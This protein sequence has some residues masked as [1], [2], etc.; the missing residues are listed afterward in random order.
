MA[1]LL[2]AVH[3]CL[4]LFTRHGQAYAVPDFTGT[5]WAEAA[6]L[7][8]DHELR[9]EVT[10]SLYLPNFPRGAVFRQV[11]PAGSL[12]KKQ[13]RVTL[14]INSVQPRLVSMPRL[15]GFSLRQAAAEL[16][17][18]SLTLGKISYVP[19]IATN[20]V[21]RQLRY[22]R[23]VA[24]GAQIE[25]LSAIDLELGLASDE[26][27]AYIPQLAGKNLSAAKE[28]LISHSLN[29]GKVTY[30]ESVKTAADS[31]AARVVRQVPEATDYPAWTYGSAVS[32][33]LSMEVQ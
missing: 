23:P 33:H 22:G 26:E 16:A 5:T 17:A 18:H 11:P 14:T 9:V 25:A 8:A 13:R 6:A 28:I 1:V 4:G 24:P 19:D 21:L 10:D 32:L 31:T 15:T 20:N 27:K 2:A 29:L 30:D 7:A 3:V 12:V